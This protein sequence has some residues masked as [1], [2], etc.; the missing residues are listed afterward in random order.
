MSRLGNRLKKV[1]SLTCHYQFSGE[2]HTRFLQSKG[3]T[4][5]VLTG[6]LGHDLQTNALW[7]RLNERHNLLKGQG[8]KPPKAFWLLGRRMDEPE[9][10]FAYA[11]EYD[12]QAKMLWD[13]YLFRIGIVALEYVQNRKQTGEDGAGDKA[14]ESRTSTEA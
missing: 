11:I 6:V 14:S 8:I 13:R 5:E 4:E 7:E 2:I 12:E 1:E 10:I 9:R 3:V